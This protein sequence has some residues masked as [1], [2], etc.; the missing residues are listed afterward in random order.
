[1]GKPVVH[2]VQPET[3]PERRSGLVRAVSEEV[4]NGRDMFYGRRFL[5]V[6]PVE[7]GED[8]HTDALGH[9][10]LEQSEFTPSCPEMF[11]NGDRVLRI[12]R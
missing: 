1:M 11:S 8:I 10:S 9:F 2:A 4:H 12:C 3:L 7:E 6:L 5:P